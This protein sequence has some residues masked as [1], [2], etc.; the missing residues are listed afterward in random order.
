MKF[1][2]F[3]SWLSKW[4]TKKES[5]EQE[6]QKGR[7]QFLG[8][9]LLAA[10]G[11]GVVLGSRGAS[12]YETEGKTTASAASGSNRLSSPGVSTGVEQAWNEFKEQAHP[13]T[14]TGY[15]MPCLRVGIFIIT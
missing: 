5:K 7:R 13:K 1:I 15:Y 3:K 6:K 4:S 11:S 10:I 14:V 9:G 12:G 2:L 8:K